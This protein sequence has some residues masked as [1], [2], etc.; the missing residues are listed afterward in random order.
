[1][2]ILLAGQDVSL[3][4][5]DLELCFLKAHQVHLLAKI[6]GKYIAESDSLLLF[7]LKNN[8]YGVSTFRFSFLSTC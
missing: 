7:L 8:M 6:S 3:S 1:M 5:I 2:T 4:P